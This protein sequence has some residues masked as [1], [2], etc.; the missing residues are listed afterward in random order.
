MRATETNDDAA[1]LALRSLAW[2]MADED[3][4]GRFLA[5]TGTDPQAIRASIG[6][7]AFLAAVLA[8]LE[9]HEPDLVACA[10]ALEIPAER[11]GAARHMLEHS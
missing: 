11:L 10:D 6:D 2:L 5:L 7:P 9:A 1:T 4:A 8:H 3:R